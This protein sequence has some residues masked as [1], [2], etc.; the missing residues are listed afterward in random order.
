MRLLEDKIKRLFIEFLIPSI[1]GAVVLALYSFVDMIAIGQ[2]VGVNGTAATAIL[3]P[4]VS[5]ASFLGLLVG[6]GGSV[7]YSRA[8]GEG[9]TAEANGAFTAST[10][11]ILSLIHISEPTRP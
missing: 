6:M 7:L 1:G 8:K 5:M 4:I 11:F 10:V 3:T 2:G 9:D